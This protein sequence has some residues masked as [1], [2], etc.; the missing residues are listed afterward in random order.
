MSRFLAET[1]DL[2]R[3]PPFTLV[4]A[5]Y[6]A[7][8]AA[9]LSDL[10]ARLLAGGIDYDV[11]QLE[12]DPLG[13]LEQEDAFREFLELQ[14]LNDAGRSL[15]LAYAVGAA[16]DHL[17]ATLFADIGLRRMDGEGDD[18][19]RTRIA[20][21]PEAKSAGTLG[22]YEYQALTA[23]LQVRDALALNYSSGLVERGQIQLMIVPAL[24][25]DPDATIA[26]V[27]LAVLDRD[28]K[29]GTD[30]VRVLL[31]T[32]APYDVTA[33]LF[34]AR[35]PDPTLVRTDALARLAVYAEDRRRAGRIIAKSGLDA[36]LHTPAV[37]RA[38]RSVPAGDVDPGAAG[39]AVLRTAT[40]T[41]EVLDV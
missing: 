17:A 18:R 6:E 7:I 1:L 30:D 26:A 29:L 31:A 38:E 35:G 25:A 3:L 34:I 13:I 39:V 22:G 2:S 21:A 16:L 10:K 24:G 32:P 15:T 33:T 14:A 40:I 9:R 4:T 19:F 11:D 41:V 20:L 27:R 37:D 28:V 23:T 5:N 12:T 36:A 8:L